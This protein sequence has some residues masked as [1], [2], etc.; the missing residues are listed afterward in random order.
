MFPD[1]YPI[2]VDQYVDVNQGDIANY[3]IS[4]LNDNID[5]KNGL[6]INAG[7]TSVINFTGP[8]ISINAERGPEYGIMKIRII[9]LSSEATP[10]VDVVVDWQEIDLYSD[11]YSTSLYTEVYA[12]NDLAYRRYIAEI[13]SDFEK[14]ILSS[15]GK[16]KI[17]GYSFIEDQYLSLK[18][19]EISPF[20]LTRVIVGVK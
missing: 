13:K 11:T 7:A 6:S 12:K 1:D 4:F 5:W 17:N 19:E 8:R 14:N 20:L 15:S 3:S 16:I 9:G 10:S 2:I 18:S